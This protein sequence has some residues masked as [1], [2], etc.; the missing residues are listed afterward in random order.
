MSPIL[1]AGLLAGYSL[2]VIVSGIYRIVSAEGGTTGLIFGL[3]MGLLGFAGAGLIAVRRTTIGA[4][5]SGIVVVFV[6]GWFFYESFVKKG[7]ENAEIRQL[8]VI[9]LS[10]LAMGLVLLPTKAGDKTSLGDIPKE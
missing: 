6:G 9:G 4:V 8:I 1:K 7:V 2:A 10:G 5:V 3:V